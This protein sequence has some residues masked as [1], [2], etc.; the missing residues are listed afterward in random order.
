M[1]YN[2]IKLKKKNTRDKNNNDKFNLGGGINNLCFI[3]TRD[4]R[5]LCGYIEFV[6]SKQT[7]ARS[8]EGRTTLSIA[9]T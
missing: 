3:P 2:K 8:P 7:S 1:V 4:V 5:L 6:I 9:Y